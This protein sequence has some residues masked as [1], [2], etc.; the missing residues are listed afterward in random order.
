MG[1]IWI[2]WQTRI[3]WSHGPSPQ[4]RRVKT[5]GYIHCFREES[6]SDCPWSCI[7][8]ARDWSPPSC[9]KYESMETWTDSVDLLHAGWEWL[10]VMKLRGWWDTKGSRWNNVWENVRRF[11]YTTLS[12]LWLSMKEGSKN[13]ERSWSR[14]PSVNVPL[15]LWNK[16]MSHTHTK[17]KISFNRKA[18]CREK[19][20]QLRNVSQWGN[21]LLRYNCAYFL[22]HFDNPCWT[23]PYSL[24][25]NSL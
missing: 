7:S 16:Q 15:L 20:F 11:I 13:Y 3:E 14:A 6:A 4:S 24:W 18:S 9:L 8:A 22:Y 1:I 5:G 25:G 19:P 21:A 2:D 10:A 12:S 23:L 17:F